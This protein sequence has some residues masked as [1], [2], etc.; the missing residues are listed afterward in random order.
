[1]LL[2]TRRENWCENQ[3]EKQ[4]IYLINPASIFLV[5]PASILTCISRSSSS[6][7]QHFFSGMSPLLEPKVKTL[8]FCWTGIFE[9]IFAPVFAPILG[10]SAAAAAVF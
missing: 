10:F 3:G 8:R 4:V 9:P 6:P 1:M 5:N 7:F 2:K